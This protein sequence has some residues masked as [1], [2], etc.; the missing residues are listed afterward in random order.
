MNL[1]KLL[2]VGG[3]YYRD[4]SV[5]RGTIAEVLHGA[6]LEPMLSLAQ[7]A[8]TMLRDAREH[9]LCAGILKNEK[10]AAL[11]ERAQEIGL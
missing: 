9:W 8:V 6:E 7:D 5:E 3:G 2:Y 4:S 10:L 11:L 1:S